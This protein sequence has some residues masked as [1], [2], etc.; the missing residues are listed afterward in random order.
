MFSVLNII[1]SN[2][3]INDFTNRCKGK[4]IFIL[5]NATNLKGFINTTPHC[6]AADLQQNNEASIKLKSI[7]G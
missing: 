2:I 1:K 4:K 7:D 3:N 5:R 6:C